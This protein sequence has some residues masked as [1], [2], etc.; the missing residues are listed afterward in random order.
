MA[1]R[2]SNYMKCFLNG[3]EVSLSF[4]GSINDL[5]KTLDISDQIVI[6]KKNG[7]I[8]TELEQVIDSDHIEVQQVIF[9][10]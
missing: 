8:V 3:K 5:L 6:V 1:S 9:G 10:G 2:V 7:E 4:S